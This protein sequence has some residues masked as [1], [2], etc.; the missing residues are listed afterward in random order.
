MVIFQVGFAFILSMVYSSQAVKFKE[1]HRKIIFLPTILSSVVVGM[2]WQ[3]IFRQD[4]GIIASIFKLV[5]LGNHIIPWLDSSKYALK[6]I[7]IVL[8]W[9]FVGNYVVIIMAS[10]QNINTSILEAAELDGATPFQKSIY[11][12]IPLLKSTMFVILIMVISGCMK[13]FDIVYVMTN[14][15]PGNATMVAVLYS[16]NK[17]FKS[18]M[19]GYSSASAILVV[20]ISTMIVIVFKKLFGRLQDE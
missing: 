14:G 8:V 20:I 19:L 11:I 2:V 10:M 3:L 12:I 16:Y 17:A 15:G 5:G 18:Q 6:S 7:S 1:V 9:Q 13:M 4:I